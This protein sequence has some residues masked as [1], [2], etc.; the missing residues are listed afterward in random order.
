MELSKKG[1]PIKKAASGKLI[2]PLK[3]TH[4]IRNNTQLNSQGR[5]P[6]FN[7]KP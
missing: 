5:N 2:V 7:A 4:P 1:P 6:K 3:L